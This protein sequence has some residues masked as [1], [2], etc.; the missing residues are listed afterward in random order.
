MQ[1][2]NLNKNKCR[3]FRKSWLKNKI[4]KKRKLLKSRYSKT[5]KH[6]I[7]NNLPI[8]Q[9]RIKRMKLIISRKKLILSLLN[10]RNRPRPSQSKLRKLRKKKSSFLSEM[11]NKQSEN[12]QFSTSLII[13]N[14][15]IFKLLL[16]ISPVVKQ[17]IPSL[18]LLK[19]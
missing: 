6:K 13:L 17:V 19:L 16:K 18:K 4:V 15:I 12:I 9:S 10:Q 2:K 8:Y 14:K 7:W 5:R 1:L 11:H 3:W